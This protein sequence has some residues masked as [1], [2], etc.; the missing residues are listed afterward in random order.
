MSQQE[1]AV[2][3][4]FVDNIAA[5]I[6]FVEPSKPL[7]PQAPSIPTCPS[8]PTGGS[9]SGST[10]DICSALTKMLFQRFLVQSQPVLGYPPGLSQQENAVTE[11]FVDFVAATI[12]VVEPSRPLSPQAPSPPLIA[13][14]LSRMLPHLTDSSLSRT[15]L[16]KAQNGA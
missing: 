5:A 12:V 16:P 4:P 11:P 8:D 7:S 3:K 13:L 9:S 2:T 6:V 10:A 14:P 15:P 1:N